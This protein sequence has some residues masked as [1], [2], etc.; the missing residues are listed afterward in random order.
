MSLFLTSLNV[1]KIQDTDDDGIGVIFSFILSVA[2]LV[3]LTFL[4]GWHIYLVLTAQVCNRGFFCS[5]SFC[6]LPVCFKRLHY[7][8]IARVLFRSIPVLIL[9][10]LPIVNRQPLIF[11]GIDNGGERHVSKERYYNM[12]RLRV[13]RFLIHCFNFN[14][15]II[16]FRNQDI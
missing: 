10:I 5:M 1:N 2:V 12:Q 14:S 15:L 6:D 3:S 13:I 16:H 8:S 7:A 4:L 11:M 9:F